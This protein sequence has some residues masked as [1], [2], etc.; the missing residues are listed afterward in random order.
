M[1]KIQSIFSP[2]RLIKS[3]GYAIH[4]IYLLFKGTIN[5][6]IHFLAVGVTSIA[7]FYFAITN[8][9]WLSILICFAMVLSTEAINTALEKLCDKINPTFDNNIK[10]I[11]DLSA[12]AV[13]ITAIISVIIGILIFWPYMAVLMH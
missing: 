13:L 4:G 9:E 1:T 10:E 2:L 11:K 5:A 6:R 3:L 7:G 12:G 8:L